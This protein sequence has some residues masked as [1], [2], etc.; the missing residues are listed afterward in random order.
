MPAL[1]LFVVACI[2]P[3]CD[4]AHV[5]GLAPGDAFVARTAGGRVTPEVVSD[6]AFIARL[7]ALAVPDGPLFEVAVVHHTQCGTAAL[8]V[9][10]LRAAHAA[11]VGLD[12]AVLAARAVTDPHATATA[13]AAL[14]RGVLSPRCTVTPLVHDVETGLVSRT[15]G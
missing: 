6:V 1:R 9:D 7:A 8:A 12:D 3:R 4:P 11:E 15:S 13:D 10:D 14:L 5:M 2:D